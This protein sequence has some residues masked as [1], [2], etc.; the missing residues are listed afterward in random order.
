MSSTISE[1]LCK[2]ELLNVDSRLFIR[3]QIIGFLGNPK[4]EQNLRIVIGKWRSCRP[5][6]YFQLVSAAGSSSCDLQGALFIRI[7][8][9]CLSPRKNFVKDHLY[10]NGKLNPTKEFL[11]IL[12]QQISKTAGYDSGVELFQEDDCLIPILDTYS[13]NSYEVYSSEP[14]NPIAQLATNID[15]IVKSTHVRTLISMWNIKLK[16]IEDDDELKAYL[17]LEQPRVKFDSTER[18]IRR[19]CKLN[20]VEISSNRAVKLAS[21]VSKTIREEFRCMKRIMN[22]PKKIRLFVPVFY[23]YLRP[24]L[25]AEFLKHYSDSAVDIIQIPIKEYKDIYENTFL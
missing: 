10:K 8:E 15:E 21:I 3:N 24:P 25:W 16:F 19:C 11:N 1:D 23:E 2:V 12:L 6:R 22:S 13:K 7:E 5:R 9:L 4:T 17:N 20:Q 14:L 18:N